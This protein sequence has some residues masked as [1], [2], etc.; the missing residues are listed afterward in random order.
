MSRSHNVP[1]VASPRFFTRRKV[2]MLSVW[3]GLMAFVPGCGSGGGKG[4]S[5]LPI[6]NPLNPTPSP[7]PTSTVAPTPLPLG[8]VATLPMPRSLPT[9]NLENQI[10]QY[11]E[12]I[13]NLSV[14]WATPSDSLQSLQTYTGA[15]RARQA[16]GTVES[17]F[18]ATYYGYR[19]ARAAQQRLQAA[20][21]ALDDAAHLGE[22]VTANNNL[23]GGDSLHNPQWVAATLEYYYHNLRFMN[24]ITA[25]YQTAGLRQMGK[26][27]L[28]SSDYAQMVVG[29]A[30]LATHFNDWVTRLAQT[31]SVTPDPSWY[32]L[33]NRQLSV[34]E[35]AGEIN[36]LDSIIYVLP[37]GPA[38]FPSQTS[39]SRQVNDIPCF[40]QAETPH[41]EGHET[42]WSLFFGNLRKDPKDI[43]EIENSKD[44]LELTI[45]IRDVPNK[46]FKDVLL[47]KAKEAV[48]IVG[49][50]AIDAG[51]QQFGDFVAK[52]FGDKVGQAADGFTRI[53][54]KVFFY[55][56]EVTAAVYENLR[57]GDVKGFAKEYFTLTVELATDMQ[58][59]IE[60][61][62]ESRNRRLIEAQDSINRAAQAQQALQTL[63]LTTIKTPAAVNAKNAECDQLARAG[64]SKGSITSGSV[65]GSTVST[66]DPAENRKLLCGQA[67]TSRAAALI[68]RT[69]ANMEL[70]AFNLLLDYAN[71]N[72]DFLQ[73][74]QNGQTLTFFR[75]DFAMLIR[76]TPDVAAIQIPAIT[77]AQLLCTSSGYMPIRNVPPLDL[78]KTDSLPV[79]NP[80]NGLSL[81]VGINVH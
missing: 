68:P 52:N 42:F 51:A 18:A 56:L 5:S 44:L 70:A 54:G 63:T 71:R 36:R 33:T 43:D 34:A 39:R 28:D 48:K 17:F 64:V 41:V 79:F 19:V 35:I 45:S 15:G 72:P 24:A 46:E 65:S 74:Q 38:Q 12:A 25:F 4:N 11:S 26:A 40:V 81:G 69:Y 20:I 8:P 55:G 61:V 76:R 9:G 58:E 57:K 14:V 37:L 75:S 22:T 73:P 6:Q 32:L 1:V 49:G 3:G 21:V 50:A 67:D 7:T 2:L 77:D 27:V 16:T 29:Y 30:F 23:A 53:T 59:E 31:V 80:L 66:S 47:D 13:D 60:K 10:N 62:E 78:S